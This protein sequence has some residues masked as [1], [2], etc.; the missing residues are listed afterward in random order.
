M[1]ASGAGAKREND[2]GGIGKTEMITTNTNANTIGS[3]LKQN[4]PIQRSACKVYALDRYALDRDDRVFALDRDDKVYAL[5]RDDK[6]NRR[7]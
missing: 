4:Q 1:S 2:E 5:D 3:P 6:V 7:R